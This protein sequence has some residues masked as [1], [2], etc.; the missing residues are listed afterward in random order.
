MQWL[1]V[2]VVGLAF[3]PYLQARH[4]YF[5]SATLLSIEQERG[6]AQEYVIDSPLGIF[7]VRYN[8]TV[9][10]S[11]PRLSLGPIRVSI[12]SQANPADKA[13]F[14]DSNDREYSATILVRN[15]HPPPPPVSRL[16]LNCGISN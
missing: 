13:Y 16:N 14:L 12:E 3:V 11:S 1:T 9:L 8:R 15:G 10:Y 4:Q 2:L 7:T 5:H 6:A